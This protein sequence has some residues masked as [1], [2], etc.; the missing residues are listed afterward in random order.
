MIE[1]VPREDGKDQEGLFG[2][3]GEEEGDGGAESY[4]G[5]SNPRCYCHLPFSGFT[6][7][8]STVIFPIFALK[9]PIW[10]LWENSQIIDIC[11]VILN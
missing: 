7:L 1:G 11:I 8:P 9:G 6:L 4:Q 2:D 3:N 5:V 10:N